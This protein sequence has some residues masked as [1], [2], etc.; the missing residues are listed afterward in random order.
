MV[1]IGYHASHEQFSP[2]ELLDLVR[3]AER[4]GFDLAKC[5]EHFHPWSRRQGQSGYAWSWLGAVLQATSLP[6]GIITAPGGRH[7]PASLAQAAAT[8]GQMYPGRLTLTLGSG[9]ALNEA[10]L[11]TYWPE[12]AERNAR[13]HESVQ[14]IRALLRGEE[15]T[16][17]GR[18][19]VVQAR[20][21]TLPGEPMPLFGAAI[22]PES[23]AEVAAWADGLLTVGGR[24]EE[25]AKV[26]T[27]FRRN[28]GA[29][30]PV[31][32]QHALS[33]AAKEEEAL[34]NALDQWA[35][36]IAGGEVSQELRHPS[37]FEALAKFITPE[38]MRQAV[39]ISSDPVVHI[40]HL[41]ALAELGDVLHLHN[42]GR[43]QAEFIRFFGAEV[44]PELR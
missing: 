15:I 2:A 31:H 9:E 4:E 23:A 40:E 10:I 6:L 11:G 18:I 22:S 16:H 19:T 17:R 33:W 39:A 44:L 7:H 43:N 20:L 1:Q 37:D 34:E 14:V 8:L 27:A 13:L 30:K 35:P 32:I 28:G 26:V 3:L 41:R 38:A 29:E 5:S 25:V 21:F 12:K 36:V 42:V 24:P